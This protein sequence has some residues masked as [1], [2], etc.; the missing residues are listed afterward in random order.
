MDNSVNSYI[1]S[2]IP[3]NIPKKKKEELYAELS[4]HVF[5]KVD[6]YKDIG[7]DEQQAVSKALEEMG[8]SAEINR[9]INKSFES[10]YNERTLTAVIIGA[11]MLVANLITVFSGAWIISAD[12]K[13]SPDTIEI[14]ISFAAVLFVL[15]AV[16]ICYVTGRRKSLFALGA[17]NVL[18]A[19]VPLW[20]LYPQCGLYSIFRSVAYLIDLLTPAVMRSVDFEGIIYYVSFAFVLIIAGVSFVLSAKIKGKGKPNANKTRAAVIFCSVFGVLSVFGT[21]C[22]DRACTYFSSYPV[23]FY[24]NYDTVYKAEEEI[25]NSINA[26]SSFD[27][28]VEML[29]EKG[30]VNTESF[31]QTLDKNT[32]KKF[33]YNL[34]QL[35]LKTDEATLIFF[36]VEYVETY[37]SYRAN[38]NRLIAL[39]R[40]A[41]GKVTEKGIGNLAAINDDTM[42]IFGTRKDDVA[43]CMEDFKSLQK[44]SDK[45]EVLSKFGN[46]YGEVFLKLTQYDE[47]GEKEYLKFYINGILNES[48]TNNTTAVAEFNFRNS[49]LEGGKLIYDEISSGKRNTHCINIT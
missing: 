2:L 42:R 9:N 45:N 43:K 33:A 29:N 4:A 14:I 16:V 48:S 34:K 37:H 39:K 46:E 27:E 5:E 15:F 3:N 25:Y 8:D 28:V 49:T 31:M 21:V 36:N 13:G 32:R 10:L 47:Y 12:L 23:W 24:E 44:G 35:E 11:V 30:Y 17:A 19:A 38:G 7:F 22:C 1:N 40:G 6:F 26:D 41:D 20:C 18:I